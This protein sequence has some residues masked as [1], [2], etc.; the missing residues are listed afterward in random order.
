MTKANLEKTMRHVRIFIALLLSCGWNPIFAQFR[1]QPEKVVAG[2]VYH[3]VKSN[4]DGSAPENVSVYLVAPDSVVAFKFHPGTERAGLVGA[5][6]DWK[7]FC[8]TR[9]TSSQLF[10]TGEK[11]LFATLQYL[12]EEKSALVEIVGAN[13]PPEKAPIKRTPFHVYNFDL[14]SLNFAFR[15]L[16]APEKSFVIGIA[17]PTFAEGAPVFA[18]KG[19]VEIKFLGEEK[20]GEALCRKYAIDGAGLQN[21]GGMIWVD[22]QA[23]HIV[24]LE[25]ALPNNRDWQSYKLRLVSVSKM[26]QSAWEAFIEDQF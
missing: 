19:E 10:Y 2:A 6:L 18:Y 23:E 14:V 7:L 20:R 11:K 3:Y 9:L 22:K 26:N 25:I 12:P 1:Y 17:D 16:I 8:A 5:K 21:R 13:L 24:D 15:H 4:L